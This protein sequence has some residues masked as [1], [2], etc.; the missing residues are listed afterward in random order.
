V[1]GKLV[2]LSAFALRVPLGRPLRLANQT[3]AAREYVVAEAA[4]D[5]GRVGRAIG[6]S[7]GAPVEAVIRRMIS[8]L[9]QGSELEHYT[10]LYDGTVGRNAMQG[11][12]G[13]FW[14]ALSL[15]DCAVHDLM[16]I[17]AGVPL[18]Q[19]LGGQPT[20]VKA[21]LAG[22]YPVADETERTIAVLMAE[23]ARY[24]ASGVKVTG[25][26]DLRRDTLRLG[27]CRAELPAETPLIVDLYNSAPPA[28]ELIPTAKA[29]AEYGM[30]WLEDP[31]AF[32]EYGELAALAD[33]LSYPVG[34]GDEQAGLAHFRNLI[35]FGHIGVVRLDATTCGG[36]TGFMRIAQLATDRGLPVSCH[37]FHHLHAQLAAVV[38]GGAVEYMLPDTGVDAIHLLLDQD[39]EWRSG[40]MLPSAEPGVGYRWNEAALQRFRLPE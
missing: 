28:K 3:I 10:A 5:E 4:D 6:Y 24:G 29:W 17:R 13:I 31:Y 9:W 39:L 16:A 25:S 30:G 15:A 35:D 26:G 11:S 21:T 1:K 32:D 33:G 40:R 36:V 22:C 23:M 12:H 38:P 7:R 37:V 27:W 20:P 14:R 19:F 2:R 34:V 8:P 18:A